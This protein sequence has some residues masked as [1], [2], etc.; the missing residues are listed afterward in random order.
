VLRPARCNVHFSAPFSSAPRP[1]RCNFHWVL[2][3]RDAP[4]RPVPR[5]AP[6][7]VHRGAPFSSVPPSAACPGQLPSF[8]TTTAGHL[9]A[10]C[11]NVNPVVTYSARNVFI[12]FVILS[13]QIVI[14]FLHSIKSLAFVTTQWDF[15]EVG[16]KRWSI[17][18]VRPRG[19]PANE[20]SEM[21]IKAVWEMYKV[22]CGSSSEKSGS[23]S[24][25][26]E[27]LRP[28]CRWV[29]GYRS[30]ENRTLVR[31]NHR[32]D[33]APHPG[34][35]K[36]SVCA[37]KFLARNLYVYIYILVCTFIPWYS[38]CLTQRRWRSSRLYVPLHFF[39]FPSYIIHSNPPFRFDTN[40]RTW[41][42]ARKCKK[43]LI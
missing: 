12:S 8:P 2:L 34:R 30:F 39:A 20:G 11:N 26:I 24:G 29:T 42:T 23:H 36:P 14:I 6:W 33:A 41:I 7:N 37:V 15:C 19:K 35:T 5:L 22:N 9:A 40:L 10:T 16:N 3:H 18:L 13:E 32:S 25:T 1:A 17:R 38:Y 31:R 43:K 27:D 4:F 28:L 21:L